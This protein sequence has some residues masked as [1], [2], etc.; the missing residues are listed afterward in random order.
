MRSGS[1]ILRSFLRS[2]FEIT[3]RDEKRTKA[4]EQINNGAST[5]E[6]GATAAMQVND[7]IVSK[8]TPDCI[9]I[10]YVHSDYKDTFNC[11]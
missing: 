7:V 8:S 4:P 1:D 5:P 3:A 2:S 10:D 6:A 9:D 11:S